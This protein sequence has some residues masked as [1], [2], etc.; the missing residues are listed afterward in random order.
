[1]IPLL[2]I[3]AGNQ[4]AAEAMGDASL[5]LIAHELLT[6]LKGSVT[7]D[8]AHGQSAQARMRVL[9]KRI[10]KRHGPPARFPGRCHP[11]G[12]PTGGSVVDAVGGGT[13]WSSI[14]PSSGDTSRMAG[15][16]SLPRIPPPPFAKC[17]PRHPS[18][19]G[20]LRPASSTGAK[21]PPRRIP[22]LADCNF[23]YRVVKEYRAA[24]S[25]AIKAYAGFARIRAES[26]CPGAACGCPVTG[27]LRGYQGCGP[28]AVTATDSALRPWR[29]APIEPSTSASTRSCKTASTR[30]W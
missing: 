21:M 10:P 25:T 29:L 22:A 2:S 5:R 11:G 4:D 3:M 23:F 17:L 27:C 9:A 13:S 1:M 7:V 8:R 30:E 12:P 14:G 19:F 26:S 24:P 16:A 15:S 6:S 28:V 18:R 20:A